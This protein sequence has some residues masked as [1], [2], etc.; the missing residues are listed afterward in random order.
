MVSVIAISQSAQ[1][2]FNP[3]DVS[4]APCTVCLTNF[5]VH[6]FMTCARGH[7]IDRDCLG[8]QV[9]VL[10]NIKDI[11]KGL[12]CNSEGCKEIFSLE[13]IKEFLDPLH[14]ADLETRLEKARV[15][16]EDAHFDRQVRKITEA[17]EEAF[18][19]CCPVDGCGSVLDQI[20]GCNTAKCSNEACKTIFCYFCLKPQ[21]NN[22]IAHAHVREHSG[23]Y[24]EQRPGYASYYRWLLVRKELSHSFKKVSPEVRAEAVHSREALLRAENMWPMPAGQMS[25]DWVL[26]VAGSDLSNEKKITLLQNE[27]IF[28]YQNEDHMNVAIVRDELERLGGLALASLDARDAAGLQQD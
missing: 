3:G 7:A 8:H 27:F 6:D 24:W 19:I 20:E 1:A 5:G 4:E 26:E 13:E 22:E 16:M 21:K 17:I 10:E 23:N 12:P 14:R 11:E 9:N 15:P 28:R 25:S 2:V 18:N